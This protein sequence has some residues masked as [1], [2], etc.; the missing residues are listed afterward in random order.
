MDGIV[1]QAVEAQSQQHEVLGEEALVS[2]V[3]PARV[4]RLAV[5]VVLEVAAVDSVVDLP[6]AMMTVAVEEED[7]EE[8]KVETQ[9]EL[10]V[11]VVEIPRVVNVAR[12][13]TSP[14]NVQAA[15]V[16]LEIPRVANVARKGILPE[17]A[18]P[19]AVVTTNATNVARRGILLE[20]V[21]L[22]VV[23]TNVTNVAR[24]GILRGIA[25]ARP[26]STQVRTV[27]LKFLT[28]CLQ[29]LQ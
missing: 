5:A 9:I 12:K 1:L 8:V 11:V 26:S 15:T 6:A 19:A 4:K 24:K 23:T 25:R 3:T 21:P 7:L 10:V 16:H 20:I 27:T 14:E 2:A 13:D 17:I 22:A 18:P 28:S 29:F